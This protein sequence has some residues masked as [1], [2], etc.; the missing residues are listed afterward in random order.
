MS[1]FFSLFSLQNTRM[2]NPLCAPRG[3]IKE[4]G[5]GEISSGKAKLVEGGRIV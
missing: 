4:F 3:R 1:P 5:W 2:R